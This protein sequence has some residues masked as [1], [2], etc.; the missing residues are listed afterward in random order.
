MT[1]EIFDKSSIKHHTSNLVSLTWRNGRRVRL[2]TV[3][4]N[5]WRFDSSREQ[6]LLILVSEG[7]YLKRLEAIVHIYNEE[8]Q[9]GTYWPGLNPRESFE[10]FRGEEPRI[11]RPSPFANHG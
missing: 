5:P 2:R 11:R 9:E 4:G 8:R 3:W 6:I 1:A 10:K 7:E